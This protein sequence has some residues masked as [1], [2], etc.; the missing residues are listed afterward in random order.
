[1]DINYN[2][3]VLLPEI[4]ELFVRTGSPAAAS[5]AHK[6]ADWFG[7]NLLREPGD[8]GYLTYYAV[9]ARTST[10]Y[11]DNVIPDP[12]RTNLASWFIPV[13]PQLAAFYTSAEDRAASRSAWA[14]E[15]GPAPGPAKLDTSPRILA[16]LPYGEA[17]APA[18]IK[19]LAIRQLPYL[20]N[21]EFAQLRKDTATNQQY[22]YAR[23]P[24]YYMGAFFGNRQTDHV[25]AGTGFFWHPDAGTLV[26]GQQTPTGCWGTVLAS[27]HPDA[28]DNLVAEYLVGSQPWDGSNV[29]P[30]SAPVTV[31]YRMPDSRVVTELTIAR[32]GLTRAVKATTAATEQI[33]LVL[34]PTDVVTFGTG[35]PA[36]FGQNSSATTGGLT[37]RR[38]T[39]TIRIAWG[40]SRAVT[41]SATT[42]TYF[43]DQ[44]RRIHVL[45]IPHGGVL[46]TKIAVG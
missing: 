14:K 44:L 28:E 3:E 15:P 5:M 17:L 8:T 10:A 42:R 37:I 31:R 19:A 16:H 39:T 32:D 18:G 12:D 30:G 29:N 13:A 23:R 22:F 41:L 40:D 1:M 11:Y 36:P 2:F 20:K 38:G 6:F 27:G 46:S 24:T 25:Y 4:A 43:K 9:S 33:P 7:Y 34:L 26:H 45:R 35:A 21:T